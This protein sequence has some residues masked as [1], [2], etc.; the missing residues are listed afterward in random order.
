M[1]GG[2]SA[3]AKESIATIIPFA[4]PN[5]PLALLLDFPA[6]IRSDRHLGYQVVAGIPEAGGT[7]N[8][9]DL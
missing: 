6:G 7:G 8:Q 3:D 2:P 5:R 9:R 4:A 1:F